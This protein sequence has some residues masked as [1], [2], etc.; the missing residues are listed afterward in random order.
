M[1]TGI[2]VHRFVMDQLFEAGPEAHARRPL[3]FS[4]QPVIPPLRRPT[5][6]RSC[7]PLHASPAPRCD[8]TEFRHGAS[9][10]GFVPS[11][12]QE[13]WAYLMEAKRRDGRPRYRRSVK[14]EPRRSGKTDG[15]WALVIGRCTRRED[16]HAA[17]SA[18]TGAKGRKR[19]LALA[20]RLE[21]WDPCPRASRTSPDGCDRDHVHYRIYRSN[22]GERIEW[23]NGSTLDVLPP[24]P[25]NY[26]GDEYDL[27][28][29][30]EA[31]E[32]AD[33]ETADELLGGINPT[34]D[35]VPTA[36]LVVAGTAG[37]VRAG[38]LWGSLLKGR[39]GVWG[40]FEYAAPDHADPHDPAT[41]LAAHPGIGTLTT[42]DVIR[43]NYD[44][45]SLLDFQREYLGQ[46]PA[47]SSVSAI[48][49]GHWSEAG[50]DLIPRPDRVG[51]AFD[52]APDGTTAALACAWRDDDGTAYL[53]VLA[54]RAGVSW[55]AAEAHRVA[56]AARVPIAYDVIGA[57][58]NPADE[59][60][61]RRPPVRLEPMGLKDVQGAAQR[62]VSGLADGTV[63]HF[64]QKDLDLAAA[65]A[66]WR[67]VGES[68]RAFGHKASSAPIPPLTAA[69]LALWAFDKAPARRS[70]TVVSAAAS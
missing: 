30:D 58:T 64:R 21:R 32:I 35:T 56:Q 49:P 6:R 2:A 1:V 61:R 60:H 25:E 8:L 50:T 13:R 12:H 29:L 69:A 52:V 17:Y 38:L 47:D 5:G 45:L 43:E 37:K 63:K 20:Q 39:A 14:T 15:I 40:I 62:L 10:I 3:S 18:Q 42:L 22:G 34:M 67:R 36:Q 24:D 31:Q 11:G 66:G 65:G 4:P 54:Y 57:N 46:W 55:L 7:R 16:Y 51:L 19:F 26:R 68:G 23:R 33:D 44:D 59:L 27:V 9:L 28:V 41:W 70:F 53:E 48:D